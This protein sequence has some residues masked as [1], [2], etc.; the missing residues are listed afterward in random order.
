MTELPKTPHEASPL[1]DHWPETLPASWYVD[2]DWHAHEIELIWKKQ[3]RHVGRAAEFRAGTMRRLN[4]SGENIVV[5]RDRDGRL[6]AFHNVCRHRGSE[7]CQSEEKPL[8]GKLIVCPYHQWSYDLDGGL[9]R[10]PYVLETPDFDKKEH[11]LFPVHVREWNGFVFLC[12][13]D[14]PPPFEDAPD[15]GAAALD[16]WPMADLVVGHRLVRDLDC[17]W[18]IFW[19]NYNECLHC[20]G[21][22]PELC[23]MVPVYRRAI[24]AEN[25]A[26][27]WTPEMPAPASNLKPGARTWSMNGKTCGPEFPGLT[28]AQRSAGYHFVTLYPTMFV[29]AHVDYVRAVTLTPLGPEKTRLEAIWLF[30]PATLAAPGFD[31]ANV[32]DFASIVLQQDGD[33]CEMNQRGLRSPK[34]RSGRLAPQEFD[35]FRFHQ[36][37]RARIGGEPQGGAS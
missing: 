30:P 24:M 28:D 7:L 9:V 3:W 27:D 12:L 17:N 16:N 1:L 20:P 14:D 6:A 5:A 26:A 23:D 21:I 36:W 32:V 11:G 22:H 35:I 13:A 10:M 25:E 37:V 33:A 31:L 19:E 29:V 2:A 34:Y 15:L 8:A 4:L 18:K